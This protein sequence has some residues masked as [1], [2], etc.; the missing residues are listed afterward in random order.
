MPLSLEYDWTET[1]DALQVEVVCK[2]AAARQGKVDVFISDC[3]IK[4][5]ARQPSSLLQLDLLGTVNDAE[6]TATFKA[7]SI[8]LRLPKAAVSRGAWGELRRLGEKKAVAERRQRSIER[9]Q[10]AAAVLREQRTTQKSLNKRL[11]TH[12]MLEMETEQRNLIDARK[13]DERAAAEDEVYQTLSEVEG[14]SRKEAR[15]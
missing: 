10:E 9:Q 3:F 6:S 15:V 13:D 5:N 12:R 1:E 11:A 4:V 7:D 8:L 14:S 2:G